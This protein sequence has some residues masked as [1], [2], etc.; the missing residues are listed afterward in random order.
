MG[1]SKGADLRDRDVYVDYPFETVM[2]RWDR[3]RQAVFRKF[4][5]EPEGLNPV[6]HDNRLVN[7]ALNFGDEISRDQYLEGKNA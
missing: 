4:Y 7:D 5:G 2:F 1:I 6:P 3:A